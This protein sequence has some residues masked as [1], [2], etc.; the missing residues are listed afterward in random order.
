V[1]SYLTSQRTHEIGVRV[2]LGASREDVLR[3]VLG[4]GMRMTLVGVAIG[5]TAAFGSTRLITKMIYGVGATDP[6][7]FAGV[8]V[9][10]S[11]VALCA[12]YIPARRA[13]RVDPMVALRYE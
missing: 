12:C 13:M 8:A 2:V 7:T 6:L 11:A 3:M 4:Q 10:L 5:I 1:I 9:L